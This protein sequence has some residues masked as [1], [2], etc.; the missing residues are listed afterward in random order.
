MMV[1]SSTTRYNATLMQRKQCSMILCV[2]KS[3]EQDII[4]F[5][6]A[7]NLE[8]ARASRSEGRNLGEEDFR[9]FGY[10]DRTFWNFS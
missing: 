7:N 1:N 3:V 5:T 8:I 4:L 9:Q 6:V 10:V 2:R